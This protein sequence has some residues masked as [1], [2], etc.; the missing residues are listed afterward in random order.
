MNV[1]MLNTTRARGGAARMAA[2]LVR[3]LN[4]SARGVRAVLYHAEDDRAD[5]SHHG[6]RRRG[7]RQLNAL[8]ARL[9]GSLWVVDLGLARDVVALTRDADLLHVHNLHGYYLD[10]P[11]VLEAWRDRPVVWTWHDM[12]GATGRC[13]AGYECDLWQ[14]GCRKCPHLEFY[15]AAWLDRAAGEYRRKQEIFFG[16]RNLWIVTPSAWLGEIAARRGFDAGRIRVV[17]NLVDSEYRAMPKADARRAVNLPADAFVALFVASDCGDP[18]KG[19]AAFA[20]ALE[21]LPVLGVAVGKP[22]RH[23]H[24]AVRHAGTLRQPAQMGCYY[25][26][27]DVLVMSSVAENYPMSVIE[28]LLSGTPVIGYATGGVPS[29]LDL[30]YCRTVEAGDV[31]ALRAMVQECVDAGEKTEAM[32]TALSA[33]AAERWSPR[34]IVEKYCD[35]YALATSAEPARQGGAAGTPPAGDFGQT[36]SEEGPEP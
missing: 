8:L 15:P 20:R 17:P 28:S 32:S 13:G 16:L 22:P 12:W 3:E 9:G 23:G 7:S 6:L 36:K 1:A 25:A 10:Y 14:G 34:K 26:A 4:R 19:Y 21:G 27:A 31:D 18:R 11:A 35:I 2:N 5:P 24:P 29:Q 33:K 30:P